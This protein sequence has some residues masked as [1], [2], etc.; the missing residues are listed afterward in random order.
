MDRKTKIIATKVQQVGKLDI[1]EEKIFDEEEFKNLQDL[2]VANEFDKQNQ[3]ERDDSIVFKTKKETKRLDAITKDA[4]L[5]IELEEPDNGPIKT[6]D[7][8]FEEGKTE[9]EG[10]ADKKTSIFT[11]N[12]D[13]AASKK[14]AAIMKKKEN[15]YMVDDSTGLKDK[16][17]R[18]L[19]REY[20]WPRGNRIKF[21]GFTILM[22]FHIILTHIIKPVCTI[23]QMV[24]L[25]VIVQVKTDEDDDSGSIVIYMSPGILAV[26]WAI[27]F[28]FPLIGFFQSGVRI[29]ALKETFLSKAFMTIYILIECI[30]NFPL[31]FFYEHP[32][33]SIYLFNENGMEKLL[34]PT[35]IFFPTIYTMSIIEI[36]RNFLEPIYFF[37]I[38]LIKWQQIKVNYHSGFFV[39]LLEIM[40]SI[41]VCRFL[42]N[43]LVVIG[44][45]KLMER[46]TKKKKS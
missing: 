29:V 19:T 25:T 5:K 6:D 44:R 31:T 13:K 35:L 30:L 39:I 8:K 9:R 2:A 7:L 28:I 12:E 27:M 40:L 23:F 46:L 34:S 17:D 41:C 20:K 43:L 36:I 24:F 10:D 45:L 22:F 18:I 15:S 1:P 11:K 16:E 3:T 32:S 33:H 42:A 14:I 37:V 21:I 4:N 26:G 38:G